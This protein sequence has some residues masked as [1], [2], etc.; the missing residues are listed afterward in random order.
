MS[1][2]DTS[3]QPRATISA[4]VARLS[5]SRVSRFF[6]S[7]NPVMP[8]TLRAILPDWQYFHFGKYVVR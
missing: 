1:S 6:R 2:T 3:S 4:I 5:A 8:T 7:R